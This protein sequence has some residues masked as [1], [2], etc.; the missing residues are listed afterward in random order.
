MGEWQRCFRLS[1]WQVPLRRQA[2]RPQARGPLV[3]LSAWV[4]EE[5][6]GMVILIG[7]L[8]TGVLGPLL[9]L[10]FSLVEGLIYHAIGVQ[11]IEP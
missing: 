9:A 6:W 3:L 8:V 7:L 11:V 1:A 5:A 2:R 10:P 4:K